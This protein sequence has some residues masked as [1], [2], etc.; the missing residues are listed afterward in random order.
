MFVG[1]NNVVRIAALKQ[2]GGLYDSITEDMATGFE[3]HR[4]R[5]PRTS[6]ALAVR[7]HAR[8]PRRR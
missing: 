7:L 8:R 2:I 6:T 1:T 4:H 3:I 5:N